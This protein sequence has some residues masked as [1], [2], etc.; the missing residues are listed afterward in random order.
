MGAQVKVVTAY[1]TKKPNKSRTKIIQKLLNENKIDLLT[2]TSSSTAR[3]FFE[4]IPDF[5]QQDKRPV[6][7][8]IGPVTAKTV[9]EFGFKPRIIPKQYTVEDLAN[10][11]TDYFS[12]KKSP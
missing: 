1:I 3:N 8:C 6:I 12:S 2:F 11:I 5:K 7:A 9:K 10:E 4:L